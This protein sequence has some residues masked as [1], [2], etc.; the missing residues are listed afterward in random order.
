MLKREQLHKYQLQ[1]I[2]FIKDKKRCGLFLG[3]GMGKTTS[4]LTAIKDLSDEFEV[5]K[6]LIIAPLRVAN[7]VWHNEIKNWEHLTDLTYSIVTGTP[8]KRLEALEK[9][10]DIYITNVDQIKWLV[11]LYKGKWPF[12]AVF[13]D[14]SS[15]FKDQKTAR[16]K[17]LKTIID[18]TE[19][20]VLLTGTPAPNGLLDLWSQTYLIDK[21]LRLGKTWSGYRDCYFKGD[22]MGFNFELREGSEK[23]IHNRIKD[24]VISMKPED[25]LEL[26]SIL[27]LKEKIPLPS[28]L[29]EQYKELEKDF[30]LE[31][32]DEEI[33]A[34]NAAVVSNKLLQ[35]CNGAIYNEDRE[36]IQI[37]DLKIDRLKNFVEENEGVN[38]LVAYNYKTDLVKLQKHFPKAVVMDK[39][40]EAVE[41]WNNN[42]I[43]MLLAHPASA[44]HGLNLQKGGSVVVW[45]GINW[46][47]ELYQ[48]FNTRLYR[49]GQTMPVRIVHIVI[50]GSIDEKV[51]D[52]SLKTKDIT[53]A[54]LLKSLK[55]ELNS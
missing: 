31:I 50:E 14:E 23:N 5:G 32:E 47:L 8:K 52:V 6:V 35:F 34:D 15:M 33:V 10:V 20:F 17:K 1:A 54:S 48:Q 12:D 28:K 27:Y 30:I 11:E 21:G 24:I 38:L 49:Q 13:I 46:S 41:R 37:H 29:M 7:T 25:Y 51:I 44:G 26:P 9:D 2:Q 4:S 55:A 42:E 53:Q 3:M 45:F 36:V 18:R 22:Y 40:G 16:F 39:K 43:S 19:Y